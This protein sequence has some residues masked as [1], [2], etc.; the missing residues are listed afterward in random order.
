ASLPVVLVR[1]VP[2][3]G[4]SIARYHLWP[5]TIVASAVDEIR[6][7]V[8]L[9]GFEDQ[10]RP[11]RQ[12]RIRRQPVHLS[13]LASWQKS[14]LLRRAVPVAHGLTP[15]PRAPHPSGVIGQS[16]WFFDQHP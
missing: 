10:L 4:P 6:I 11:L 9:I 2:P 14:S 16:Q 1:I 3:I 7:R 8:I 12:P 5:D 15:R 13:S